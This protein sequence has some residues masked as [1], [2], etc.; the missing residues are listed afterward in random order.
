M[1]YQLSLP[2]DNYLSQ[3]LLNGPNLFCGVRGNCKHVA[4]I[5]Q[6][7]K[8]KIATGENASVTLMEQAWDLPSG[9]QHGPDLRQNNNIKKI[10][11]G[12]N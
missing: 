2:V 11:V 8:A 6:H 3:Q 7:I 10:N 1:L 9:Q 12:F 5:C 4:G